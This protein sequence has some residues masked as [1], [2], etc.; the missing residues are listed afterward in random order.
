MPDRVGV[1]LSSTPGITHRM[2]TGD[3]HVVPSDKGWRVEVEAARARSTHETQA[4]AR[5]AAREIARRSKAELLVHGR[6]GQIR[7]RNTYGKDPRKTKG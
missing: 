7:E 6:N 4:E 5:Q 1:S 3:V 2:A